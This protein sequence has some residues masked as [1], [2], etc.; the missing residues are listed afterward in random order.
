M[1]WIGA[2]VRAWHGMGKAGGSAG[3]WDPVGH[4]SGPGYSLIN[5]SPGSLQFCRIGVPLDMRP[6]S[7]SGLIE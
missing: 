1:A 4:G 7:S 6:G 5:I 3:A 2:R